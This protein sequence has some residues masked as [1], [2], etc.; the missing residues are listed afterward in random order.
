MCSLV[1]CHICH[2]ILGEV[3]LQSQYITDDGF[4][5]RGTISSMALPGPTTGQ[6]LYRHYWWG[7]LIFPTVTAFLDAVSEVTSHTLPP[8]VFL[9]KSYRVTLTLMSCLSVATIKGS[10]PMP[11]R[12]YELEHNLISLSLLGLLVQEAV[13]DQ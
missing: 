3:V 4:L 5:L 9:H 6:G 13:F 7:C 1:F 11:L 8:E 10:I 12:N 2:N